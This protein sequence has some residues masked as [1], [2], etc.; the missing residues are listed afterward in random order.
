MAFTV[1][2]IFTCKFLQ[3]LLMADAVSA[4]VP[5]HFHTFGA[6]I[7]LSK[8][9]VCVLDLFSFLPNDSLLRT[10]QALG[11]CL[12]QSL[13]LRGQGH[14]VLYG[15]GAKFLRPVQLPKIS[16]M[17]TISFNI[18][19]QKKKTLR[20]T[21]SCRNWVQITFTHPN[22]NK[23][24]G[25]RSGKEVWGEAFWPELFQPETNNRAPFHW[26]QCCIEPST[27]NTFLKEKKL[28]CL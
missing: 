4:S 16:E 9:C 5:S 22:S 27:Y 7:L 11:S 20:E 24:S 25:V 19:N 17:Q 14:S 6:I 12:W 28:S 23:K 21:F 2:N 3:Q 1:G 8:I 18:V 26:T 15:T 13:D 10:P